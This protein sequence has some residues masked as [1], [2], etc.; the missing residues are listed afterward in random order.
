V[1]DSV[2]NVIDLVGYVDTLL[3]EQD[4]LWVTAAEEAALGFRVR[5]GGSIAVINGYAD[6]LFIWE[7]NVIFNTG[8]ANPG[9]YLE[10]L[11]GEFAGSDSLRIEFYTES[12]SATQP[13]TWSRTFF[14][15]KKE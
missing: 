8:F 7:Q 6:S 12:T 11:Y 10:T 2:G 1:Y 4:T 14:Q 15:G 13:T 9:Y 5:G 3:S